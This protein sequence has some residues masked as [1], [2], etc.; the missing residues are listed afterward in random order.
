MFHASEVFELAR[1]IE[2]NGRDFYQALATNARQPEIRQLFAH[3]AR[4]EEQ[5]IID[6]T[7]LAER[8]TPYDPPET[9]PGEYREYMQALAD[10]SVFPKNLD[11]EALAR[12]IT[13]DKAALELAIRFEKD[14]L[15]F[16]SGLKN[17]VS[18]VENRLMD[19]LLRQERRHLCELHSALQGI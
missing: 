4:E 18:V 8:A 9:Y 14:S 15:L 3:L 5:H 1:S 19:D 2:V 12:E 16:F 6:F 17:I 10:N 11:V 7:Q 13:T